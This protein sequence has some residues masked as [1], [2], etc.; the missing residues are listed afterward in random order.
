[1]NSKSVYTFNVKY[2][3]KKPSRTKTKQKKLTKRNI[4]GFVKPQENI[5]CQWWNGWFFWG[6]QYT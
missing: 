4:D 1:M 2:T 5:Q 6:T 3:K